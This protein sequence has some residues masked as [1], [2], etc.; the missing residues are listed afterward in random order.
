MYMY[1]V[2]HSEGVNMRSKIVGMVRSIMLVG[3]QNRGR[4]RTFCDTCP[5]FFHSGTWQLC[6]HEEDV[7]YR[8]ERII[9][10]IDYVNST[11]MIL[12]FSTVTH[13]HSV[14][15]PVL[16]TWPNL[17]C[18]QE[19]RLFARRLSHETCEGKKLKMESTTSMTVTG[20]GRS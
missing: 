13:V 18:W 5:E 1:K 12:Q 20:Q 7:V 15:H 8:Y 3:P 10:G 4:S 9:K 17:I 2:S 11:R 14:L 6:Q 19:T 16:S